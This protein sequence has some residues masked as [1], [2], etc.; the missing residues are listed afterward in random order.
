MIERIACSRHW[1]APEK[2]ALQYCGRGVLGNTDIVGFAPFGISRKAA[3]AVA[4]NY[5]LTERAAAVIGGLVWLAFNVASDT[6]VESKRH[7]P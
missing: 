5:G 2:K 7:A 6:K 4:M 3:I 1:F